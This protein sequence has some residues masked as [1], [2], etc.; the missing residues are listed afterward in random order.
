MIPTD[1]PAHKPFRAV[2]RMSLDDVTDLIWLR[3]R[4]IGYAIM[5][6]G[7]FLAYDA[8]KTAI[9]TLVRMHG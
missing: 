3:H 7:M 9:K 1:V 2:T 5:S 6:L 4:F 8:G